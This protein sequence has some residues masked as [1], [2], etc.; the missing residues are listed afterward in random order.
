MDDH[1]EIRETLAGWVNRGMRFD[2]EMARYCGGT[3]RVSRRVE[4]I[5]DEASGRLVH[6]KNDCIMLEGVVC[7]AECSG[8]RLFCPR[9][10]P[11]YWREIWLER[12]GSG[13]G[14]RDAADSDDGAGDPGG[15]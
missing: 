11:A 15:G 3:Y 4:R 9:A 14:L 2:P 6:L 1:D 10:I 5:I 7:R 13:S 12:A 8:G